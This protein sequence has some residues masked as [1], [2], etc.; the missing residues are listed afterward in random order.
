MSVV[1]QILRSVVCTLINAVTGTGAGSKFA[2]PSELCS[3]AWQ[4]SFDAAPSGVS[5]TLEVSIDG[6]VWTIIDTS[7]ATAG[8]VRTITNSTAAAFIRAN[9]GTNSG[10]KAVTVVIIAKSIN[11]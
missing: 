3:L 1:T 5:I 11:T 2:L 10:S 6:L 9:V 7:T 4:T 8:E